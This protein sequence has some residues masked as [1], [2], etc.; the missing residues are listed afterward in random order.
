MITLK[1]NIFPFI[2]KRGRGSALIVKSRTSPINVKGQ[3][4]ETTGH[5]R[6]GYLWAI[7]Q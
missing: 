2:E 3:I 5:L 6:Y 4:G 1:E 7:T